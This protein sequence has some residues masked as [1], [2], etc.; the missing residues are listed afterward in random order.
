MEETELQFYENYIKY[1]LELT[2]EINN[3]QFLL[4]SLNKTFIMNKYL[5]KYRESKQ[6]FEK[7]S[8]S[9]KLEVLKEQAFYLR[10]VVEIKK[11]V[12]IFK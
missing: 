12:G 10:N 4:N 5:I 8:E 2:E 11:G 7:S 3:L 6:R 1:E 9:I